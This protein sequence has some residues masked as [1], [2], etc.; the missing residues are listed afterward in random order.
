MP[1]EPMTAPDARR[2]LAI[3]AA[4]TGDSPLGERAAR[5][6][7]RHIDPLPTPEPPEVPIPEEI[8]SDLTAE[9]RLYGFH[10]TLKPPFHLVDG[11]NPCEVPAAVEELAA[12]LDPVVLPRLVPAL[13][14]GCACLVPSEVP[15][16]MTRLERS[17]VVELDRFRRPL[18]EL[19]L[20]RRRRAEL[21]D[22]QDELLLAYG[23]PWLL[24]E[25]ELHLTLTRRLT[26]AEVTPVLDAVAEWFAPVLDAPVVIEDLCVVEQ[27]A[28]GEPFVVTTRHALGGSVPGTQG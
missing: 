21:T 22:R 26:A 1:P 12:G 27:P 11:A 17:C 13:V 20:A 8:W 10:A 16:S 25:F 5:W 14:R 2:R 4:P 9:P 15:E 18:D 7:G 23:Y 3:Y 24:D 19:D 6:L 28:P